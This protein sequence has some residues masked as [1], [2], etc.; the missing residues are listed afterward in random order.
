ML[1][2]VAGRSDSDVVRRALERHS[3]GGSW[4][5]EVYETTGEERV[6]EVVHA[7]VERGFDL[8]VAAGGDGT[9]SAVIDGLA[10]T[11]I[12]LGIIPVGTGN[13]LAH[14]LGVPLDLDGALRLL[15]G[16]HAVL[17]IDA[18]QAD[19]A[20]DARMMNT[21]D[22]D[23]ASA[24][25][26][27]SVGARLFVLSLSVG[28]SALMMRDTNPEDKRR[29][30]VVAYS[31]T[32]LRKLLGWQPHHFTLEVD[33]Q[34]RR[35]RASEVAVVN[36]GALGD[37]SL[38]WGSHIHLNDGRL[39]VCII[40]AWN[41]IDY[42]RLAWRVLLGQQRQDAGIRYLR[43][44]QRVVVSARQP[45]PVQADGEFVG[46]TP[47]QVDLLPGVVRVIVPTATVDSLAAQS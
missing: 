30:G 25:Q 11:D 34:E 33:G 40:R 45:L 4:R 36:S 17:D 35:L 6:A 21:V 20:S 10:D 47:V 14:E 1:N 27:S 12:P 26:A 46:R 9:V 16:E 13:A 44:E 22:G 43:A 24:V 8:F 37:P 18:M 39:D 31:W 32:G 5:V 2:P 28:V 15:M 7:A 19:V 42:L 41:A 23:R 38:R 3:R 29:L